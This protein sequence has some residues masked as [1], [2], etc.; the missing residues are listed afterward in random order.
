MASTD[1]AFAVVGLLLVTELLIE[2]KELNVISGT[3]IGLKEEN[4]IRM[5]VC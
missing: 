5:S 4:V 3:R 2:E 1:D